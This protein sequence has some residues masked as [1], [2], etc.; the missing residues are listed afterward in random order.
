MG[1]SVLKV[2]DEGIISV[3]LSDSKKI[4]QEIIDSG[5]FKKIKIEKPNK[6]KK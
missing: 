6:K 3:D 2:S 1:S 5:I 4:A